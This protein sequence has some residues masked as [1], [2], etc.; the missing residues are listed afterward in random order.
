VGGASVDTEFCLDSSRHN[1]SIAHDSY[2]DF[3]TGSDIGSDFGG[4]ISLMLAGDDP[5]GL[6]RASTANNNHLGVS[7]PA[8]GSSAQRTSTASVVA[9]TPAHVASSSSVQAEGGGA[10]PAR[11]TPAPPTNPKGSGR[12]RPAGRWLPTPPPT[13]EPKTAGRSRLIGRLLRK[14]RSD[15]PS[16][17]SL[18]QNAADPAATPTAK[19]AAPTRPAGSPRT[20]SHPRQERARGSTT[21][22]TKLR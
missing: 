13:V 8:H 1:T 9:S 14:T 3:G 18:G 5:W 17:P 20:A 15:T 19:G 6:L 7:T 10:T 21:L 12:S 2:A 11:F 4:N 16:T 22:M